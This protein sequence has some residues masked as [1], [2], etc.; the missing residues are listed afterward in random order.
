M[1]SPLRN[2]VNTVQLSR[3]EIFL[4]LILT[5]FGLPMI[6]LIPPGAGYDEEDHL[7]RVWE[8]SAASFIPGQ[9]PPQ[10]LR[11]PT[12]FRDFAYR[13]Q[14][15]AGIIDSDFWQSYARAALDEHGYVRREI[16][17]KSVYSPALLLPQAVAMGLFGRLANLPALSAFYLCRLAGLLSYLV[18]A[19]LAVRQIPFGKWILLVLAV[20][21]M[22]LFQAATLTPDAI[23][24]GIGFLFIAGCLRLAQCQE[25]GW[26]DVKNLILLIFLLFLAK[27]NLVPL[28]L[29]PFLLIPPAGFES[30]K[31]Y[32]SLLAI[33][34]AL[35]LLEV[36]GWNWIA[37]RNFN[38]LLLDEAHPNAQLLH[39]IGNPFAFLQTVLKDLWTNGMLYIQGWINGYGYYYWTPPQ[40]V[41]FFFVVSQIAA[42]WMDST[43]GKV[44]KKHRLIFLLVFMVGYV[45]TIASLYISY[46]PVGADQVFGVQGR[47]FIPLA[48]PPLLI[49]ASFPWRRTPALPSAKWGNILLVSTLSLNLLG[50]FL[51][52]HVPCGSTFYQTG[53][54][55]RPL[56]KDFPSEVRA[57]EP[58]SNG[59]SLTQ[60]IRVACDGLSEVRVLVR[61]SQ[62]AAQ[63]TTHFLLEDL[64][65]TQVLLDTSIANDQ[66]RAE[67]WLPIRFE[68]DWDS[69][70]KQYRLEIS[71]R[72]GSPDQGLQLFY[73]PQS[74][75]NLGNS[76]ENGQALEQDLLLQYGC[77]TGLRKLW[78]TGK[79]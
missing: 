36:A 62:A 67:D 6:L 61:R 32:V 54:C 11:Y 23:S 28:V 30:R 37:S 26:S 68:P 60:E 66:I 45:A 64:S 49:L 2:R 15:S 9:L 59:K 50:I 58:I 22:A 8:L 55:Y 44:D 38:S 1:G 53:L 77:V 76:Y 29:L 17:T 20:S 51:S 33:A 3:L 65:S 4:L 52:F 75:F 40:I 46:T 42:I 41:S 78:M 48:L 43:A 24:N 71:S 47:Y 72:N 21:P 74:E 79:P 31:L 19:W 25:L 7:V 35:F 5:L 16:D 73:T 69:A 63:G 10:E 56:F 70:G 13:Q 12:V 18:L 57:S 34:F 14:G 39:M 27:L